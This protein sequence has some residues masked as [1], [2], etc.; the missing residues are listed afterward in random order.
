MRREI[1]TYK[2]EVA[3]LMFLYIVYLGIVG[4]VAVL[5]VVIWPL[6]LFVAT[7][8]GMEWASAQAGLKFNQPKKGEE[9]A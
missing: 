5:E 2:R 9:D 7:A 1:K 3:F 4:A 8:F 6:M